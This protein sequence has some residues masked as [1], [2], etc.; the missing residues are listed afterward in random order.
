[1]S[2]Q[3]RIDDF[4]EVQEAL[5][6]AR[7]KWRNIGVRLKMGVSDLDCINAELGASI[8]N[9][10]GQ[11]ISTRLKKVEPCTWR[12][13]YNALNH[14]TV[15]M[16]DVANKLFAKLPTGGYI[17]YN[18]VVFVVMSSFCV[19]YCVCEQLQHHVRLGVVL[20]EYQ[21]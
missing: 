15:A 6:E 14:P 11:M 17:A 5:W 13:L 21:M 10:F 3:L 1:M 12:D 9:K 8:D 16:S 2:P 18:S 4:A 7:S 19:V 20:K